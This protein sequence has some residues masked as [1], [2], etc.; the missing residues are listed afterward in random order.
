M[1]SKLNPTVERTQESYWGGDRRV[2][3]E[4]ILDKKDEILIKIIKWIL[5]WKLHCRKI[6]QEEMKIWKRWCFRQFIKE[7]Q[8]T[9]VFWL[10][11]TLCLKG[12]HQII[13]KVQNKVLILVW[14]V[15][16]FYQ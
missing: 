4:N 7:L 5:E 2:K 8:K 16:F 15:L 12:G 9:R 11:Q 10:Q 13:K 3:N 6:C 14:D 1:K